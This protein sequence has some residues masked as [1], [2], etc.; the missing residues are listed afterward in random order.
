[1]TASADLR[2]AGKLVLQL[3]SLHV[4]R[5]YRRAARLMFAVTGS[6]TTGGLAAPSRQG[7]SGL[8]LVRASPPAS[9]GR[10][11]IPGRAC[12][13]SQTGDLCAGPASLEDDNGMPV[14]PGQ[15]YRIK[16]WSRRSLFKR[17]R[18]WRLRAQ[19]AARAKILP[20]ISPFIASTK[21]RSSKAVQQS[22]PMCAIRRLRRITG[23]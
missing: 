9:H 16:L 23:H 1:M 19:S 13:A 2:L 5:R 6:R 21:G 7:G 3:A 22:R 20:G 18:A 15:S 12:T 10:V 4:P 14:L 8:L 11:L 17:S